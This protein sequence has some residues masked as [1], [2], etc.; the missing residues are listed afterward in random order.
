MSS[1]RRQER[2]AITGDVRLRARGGSR[3]PAAVFDVSTGG[4]RV[5]LA[6]TMNP[7]DTMW[8]GLPG[9]EPLQAT[10]RWTDG[11][12]AGVEFERPMHPSVLELVEDRIRCKRGG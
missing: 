5:G 1:G 6:K 4:C 11:W 7:G 9:I 8:I 2:R 10:I 3:Y 12:T